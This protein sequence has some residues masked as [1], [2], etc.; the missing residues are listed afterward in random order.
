MLS[1]CSTTKFEQRNLGFNI[2][3]LE[4]LWEAPLESQFF[5][6]WLCSFVPGLYSLFKTQNSSIFSRNLYGR[7]PSDLFYGEIFLTD[8]SSNSS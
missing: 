1:I 8:I 3:K 5:K 4:F 2:S 7:Y 6:Y